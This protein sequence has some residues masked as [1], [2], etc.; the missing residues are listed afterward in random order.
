MDNIP[1]QK[2]RISWYLKKGR[3]RLNHHPRDQKIKANFAL[4]ITSDTRTKD[5]DKTGRTAFKIL[6][7]NGH[8]VSFYEIVP[9]DES[10]IR[11][12]I[13]ETLQNSSLQA[14]I[15]SGGTG[16]GQKDKTVDTVTKLFE[17]E[18]RGF[19]E[20]FRRLSFDEIGVPGVMS[21]ATAGVAKG[22]LI[23]CLPGSS[24]A[25][26]TALDQIIMPGIGHMLWELNR[27]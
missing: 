8:E 25:M 18:L 23:F 27:K 12:I 6:E 15:T 5:D 1:P 2:S 10:R 17:K 14:V 3:D 20:H 22:K 24:G 4:I 13:G 16:I 21:R 9:N 7:E 11:A 19:G 26:K